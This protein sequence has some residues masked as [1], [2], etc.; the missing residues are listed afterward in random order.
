MTAYVDESLRQGHGSLYV[1]A[2]A[3]VTAEPDAAREAARSVLVRRQPRFH[4]RN[5]SEKRR[6]RM[7]EQMHGLGV[8]ARIYM[9]RPIAPRREAGARA[10]CLNS[11]LWD[12]WHSDVDELV[13]ETR[14][15]HNDRVDR[16]TI[17]A[18]QKAKRA[19]PALAYRFDQPTTEPL[20]WFADALAGAASADA[21][22]GGSYLE[23]LGELV[24][25]HHIEP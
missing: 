3:V 8:D 7:L 4:W 18:A 15:E 17:L 13:L 2:A 21:A 23:L 20:L 1:V 16:R 12:L 25:R 5:E 14:Q 24:T 6:R 19:S 22:D 11:M 9:C 10:L